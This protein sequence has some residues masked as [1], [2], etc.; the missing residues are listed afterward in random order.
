M[1]VAVNACRMAEES[2][3]ILAIVG[4]N[5]F[6]NLWPKRIIL[7]EPFPFLVFWSVRINAAFLSRTSCIALGGWSAIEGDVQGNLKTGLSVNNLVQRGLLNPHLHCCF[8]G[9]FDSFLNRG[10]WLRLLTNRRCWWP[11]TNE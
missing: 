3:G 10:L 4:D 5:Y 11:M 2:G 9:D 1:P 6:A 7:S 8:D